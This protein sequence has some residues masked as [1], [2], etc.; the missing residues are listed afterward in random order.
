MVLLAS[1]SYIVYKYLKGLHFVP[2]TAKRRLLRYYTKDLEELKDRLLTVHAKHN[3]NFR[4]L[5]IMILWIKNN[6]GLGR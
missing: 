5:Q 2:S 4:G 3:D 6:G 1:M